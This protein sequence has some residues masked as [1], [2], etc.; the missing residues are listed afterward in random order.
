MAK[1][2]GGPIS[3]SILRDQLNAYEKEKYNDGPRKPQYKNSGKSRKLK[4]GQQK[5]WAEKH[6]KVK[7]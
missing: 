3:W 6:G 2:G 1:P 4:K 7:S 5:R